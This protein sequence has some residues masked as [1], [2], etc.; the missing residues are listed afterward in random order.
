M[1]YSCSLRGV[2]EE[3]PY[4]PFPS[5]Q[6]CQRQCRG[7]PSVDTQLLIYQFAPEGAL[8]LAP[9]DQREVLRRL[10]NLD[11]DDPSDL[12][13]ILSALG[14]NDPSDL[15]SFPIF[16]PTLFQQGLLTNQNLIRN[17]S[18]FAL[19]ELLRRY[20]HGELTGEEFKEVVKQA[21]RKASRAS[22][23]YLLDQYLEE[24]E[25]G[26]LNLPPLITQGIREFLYQEPEQV[27]GRELVKEF[28][29]E[30][31]D[32]AV[33]LW[34]AFGEPED[35]PFLREL[36]NQINFSV[37]DLLEHNYSL[38]YWQALREQGLTWEE[39]WNFLTTMNRELIFLRDDLRL[40]R[41]QNEEQ[42]TQHLAQFEQFLGD[43]ITSDYF[44]RGA[45]QNAYDNLSLVQEIDPFLAQF[46]EREG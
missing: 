31:R 44:R 19:E 5:L 23:Q 11:V 28:L 41:T 46:F 26:E 8:V 33:R 43:L 36:Y 14:T 27:Q 18:P 12:R 35:A 38:E 40:N 22:L 4:G 17:A 24:L 32:W 7:T 30:N 3:D 13:E 34:T 16:Y 6:D 9:S 1:N 29:L 21:L 15:L 25:Q 42:L 20:R 39:P 45:L 37:P 2:C 10:Q